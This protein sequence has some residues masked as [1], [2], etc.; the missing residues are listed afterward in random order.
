MDCFGSA[1]CHVFVAGVVGPRLLAS[2]AWRS[3]IRAIPTLQN[4]LEPGEGRT[5]P[6]MRHKA[7]P[8]TRVSFAAGVRLS[9]LVA[10]DSR[11]H[12]EWVDLV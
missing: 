3:Q 10:L 6:H 7:S 9:G 8:E 2:R 4:V 12:L 1:L 11:A 5:S